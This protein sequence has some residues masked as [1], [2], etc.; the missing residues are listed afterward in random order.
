MHITKLNVKG[1]HCEACEALIKDIVYDEGG[2]ATVDYK[3]GKV[4]IEHSDK[5]EYGKI[6]S[7][8]EEEGY[9]VV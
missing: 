1:L 7:L 6:V 4:S 9:E 5:L 3:S 8:I 2:N